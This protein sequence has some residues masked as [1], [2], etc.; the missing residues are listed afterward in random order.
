[1]TGSTSSGSPLAVAHVVLGL[2]VGG[3]ERVTVN[4]VRGLLSSRFQPIVICLEERGEFAADIERL[5]VPFYVLGKKPGISWRAI[6]ELAGL[7][8]THDVK[9]VHTHNAAPHFHG[10]AAALLAGVPVRVH[11]KHG[12]NFP[13]TRNKE[14]VNRISSWATDVVVA[15]SDDAA[16]LAVRVER[17]NPRKVRRIWNGVDTELYSPRGQAETRPHVIG[18][19]ARLSVEKDQKTMLAAFRLV[20]REVPEARLVFAGDGLSAP[21]LKDTAMKLGIADSVTFLGKCFDIP[22]VLSQFSVFTLSSVTEGISM[23]ILEAMATGLPVVATD[24]GG[25]RE[26]VNPPECG[27]IVPPREP[28][29]LADAY[30]ALLCDPARRAKM[31][32][33]ARTRIVQHFSLKKMLA[34][35]IELY[36]ELLAKKTRAVAGDATP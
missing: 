19:V 31:G 21:E 35:Y 17:V 5:G 25:N 16:N 27:L 11:T 15:V 9:I 4:L 24:V 33:A 13:P 30:L 2:K 36:E 12:R 29:A 20:T 26:I 34:D 7:F 14:R 18:T 8:R 3:L 28:R 6:R 10:A 22:A 1:M 32:D 23:T